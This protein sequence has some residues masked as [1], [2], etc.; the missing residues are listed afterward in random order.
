MDVRASA[1]AAAGSDVSSAATIPSA[2]RRWWLAALALVTIVAAVLRLIVLNDVPD[3][4]FYDA[5]VRSMTLSLHNFLYG[6]F[7]PSA[8]TA[9]DKPP[10]DLWLQVI[11]V[12]LFGFNSVTLKLPE[13]I[14]G[15][16]AIPLLYDLVRRLAGPLAGLCSAITLTILPT[17]VITARSDTMDSL[18]MLL[19]VAIAWLLV[20]SVQRHDRR[21]LLLAGA[22]LGLD[23]NIKLFEA[24]VAAP[25]F[26]LFVSLC[27]SG[28][29]I[30]A[31][32]RRLLAPAALFV[33]FALGWMVFVTL[34]PAHDRPY[35]IGSTNGSVWNSV[36]V[37]DG[38]DRIAKPAAPASFT[39]KTASAPLAHAAAIHVV[40][41]THA[42]NSK[43][44]IFRLFQ[45]SE[46]GYGTR[47]GT[48]LFA[49]IAF[50]L[51]ALAPW[52]RRRL[53]P[54][55]DATN[56]QRFAWAATLATALWLIL[57][58][59]LFSF[60]VHTQPRYLEA[61]TPA[62]AIA[63]G[64][65]LPVVVS[66]ARDLLGVYVL[67]ATFA[68]VMLEGAAETASGKHGYLAITLGALLAVPVTF[69][70]LVGYVRRVRERR[71]PRWYQPLCVTIGMLG[72]ILALPAVRDVLLIRDHSGA[73]AAEVPIGASIVNPISRYLRSHQG[74]THYEAAFTASTIAAPFIVLA[75]K[76]VL[77]LTTVNAQPL[78]TL[79]QLQ[80]DHAAGEVRY[81]VTET[82]CT[83]IVVTHAACSVAM[84]WVRKHARDITSATGL[85][86]RDS[87]LLY[88]LG[89]TPT[90]GGR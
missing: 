78:V 37:W 57:G 49:A 45:Y 35:A 87:G 62:V 31:R 17:A 58:Y 39:T 50:A 60:S 72:A 33:V 63:L 70:V 25:A 47:L 73:Q 41:K 51:V 88:D 12:K 55:P 7:D 65:A 43:P 14:A 30:V 66:R 85:P 34:S 89:S 2:Q 90:T 29:P 4:L 82:G 36:F 59:A 32:L 76:P 79:A 11:T 75:A 40:A 80:R 13:A 23:F 53:R 1:R 18:M 86:A 74:A 64:C 26:L 10:I 48:V 5:S 9:I 21:L 46:V 20:R 44:G 77:L 83:K 28:E 8:A 42:V 54:P 68:I 27:W 24:L 38:W 6:A 22:L 61:F 3:N 19:L 15:T 84:Q 71:W 67:V 52:L 56:E 69:Y 81:V 16:L